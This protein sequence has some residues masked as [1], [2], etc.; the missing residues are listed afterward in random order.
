MPKTKRQRMIE[1]QEDRN[2][3]L[4][5]VTGEARAELR[6][7]ACACFV[8]PRCRK[9]IAIR[10]TQLGAAVPNCRRCETPLV[11]TAACVNRGVLPTLE[12]ERSST[13]SGDRR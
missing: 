11:L 9:A 1:Q 13:Y 10:W 6:K 3:R 8:C 7:R 12:P 2:K 5:R 4:E